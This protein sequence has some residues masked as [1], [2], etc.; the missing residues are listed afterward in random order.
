M[1]NT[2]TQA[3]LDNYKKKVLA[4]KKKDPKAFKEK[5]GKEPPRKEHK[6]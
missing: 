2:S 6:K 1:A 3:M 4:E 5:Y